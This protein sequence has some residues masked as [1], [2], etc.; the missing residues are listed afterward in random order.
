VPDLPIL[1]GWLLVGWCGTVPRPRPPFP[2]TPPDPDPWWR[3]TLLTGLVGVV[4]G[5]I[6]GWAFDQLFSADLGSAAGVLLTFA[7]AFV[8]GRI[9]NDIGAVGMSA[10]R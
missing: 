4:G 6:G 9:A 2:P 5:V 8:G 3:S 10:R 1:V 7:G